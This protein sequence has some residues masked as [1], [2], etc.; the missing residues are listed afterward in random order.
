MSKIALILMCLLGGGMVRA[1]SV[2]A[3]LARMDKA[4]PAFR[5]MTADASMTTHTAIIN[6]TN[7]ESG[8]FKM[9]RMKGGEVRAVLDFSGQTDSR[10]IGFLGKIV[11]I[12]YPKL[13]SYQDYDLGKNSDV[14]NQFLL[15]GFGSSGHDLSNAYTV[16]SE[17][18]EKLGSRE[19]TKLS[20]VPKNPDVAKRLSKIEMWIPNDAA[21]PVQQEF[22]EPS[23]NYRI[24]SYTNI[25]LKPAIRGKLELKLPPGVKKQS[26]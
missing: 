16:T 26:S 9:Q 14:L 5:S 8:T 15:L 13:N 23:G 22:Y 10:Q 6:D 18:T 2:E 17:G 4:A 25:N 24:V 21:Y 19:T 3:V 1:E 12:Y 11:R 20:L 7:T